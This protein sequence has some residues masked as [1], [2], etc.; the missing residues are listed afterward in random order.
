M[1]IDSPASPSFTRKNSSNGVN[2]QKNEQSPTPPPHS[3]N[4]STA[5]G[6]SFKL[7]GNKYFKAGDY[8]RSIE[9]YNKGG[10][11]HM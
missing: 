5:E 10:F 6:D 3:A 1:D 11:I 4:P 9:E 2:G 8:H 7:A